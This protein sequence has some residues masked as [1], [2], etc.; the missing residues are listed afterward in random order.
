MSTVTH[1][2]WTGLKAH[3]DLGEDKCEACRAFQAEYMRGYRARTPRA[4]QR[5]VW[6]GV[7]RMMAYRRLSKM[8]PNEFLALLDETRIKH[9]FKEA[10]DADQ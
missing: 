1:G 6:Q 7:T 9:P 10:K 2:G 5:S 3:Q 4:K 8:Y